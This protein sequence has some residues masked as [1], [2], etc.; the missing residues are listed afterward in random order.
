MKVRSIKRAIN[1]RRTFTAIKTAFV[2]PVVEAVKL[3]TVARKKDN[4]VVAR[5][6]TLDAANEL[7]AKAKAAKKASLF[8]V[9]LAA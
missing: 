7:I 6:V 5:D 2:A 3:F 8:V 1:A 9:E 4:E